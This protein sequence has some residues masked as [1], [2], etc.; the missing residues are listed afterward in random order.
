MRSDPE[1]LADILDATQKIAAKV[2]EGHAAFIQ[3][4]YA[5]L[6]GPA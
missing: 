2:C 6:G 5:Q 1:R 3:D 4:E